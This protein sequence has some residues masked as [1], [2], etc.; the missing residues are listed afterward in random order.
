MWYYN[1]SIIFS[2]NEYL[3][4]KT[5]HNGILNNLPDINLPW[6]RLHISERCCDRPRNFSNTLPKLLA[7][8][9]VKDGERE[10]SER[11]VVFMTNY[12][13]AESNIVH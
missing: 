2:Y 3:Q 10:R 13:V 11:V 9:A 4:L 8:H 12:L 6:L 1:R 7:R 5:R